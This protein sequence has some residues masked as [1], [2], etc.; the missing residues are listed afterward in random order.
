MQ[1]THISKWAGPLAEAPRN[2]QT[3]NPSP[4]WERIPDITRRFGIK[5]SKLYELLQLRLIKSISL[6]RRGNIRGIRLVSTDS[7]RSYL[8]ALAGKE[9]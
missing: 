8:A 9:E 2:L 7:V 6:C 1:T 5:R 4:E 3:N